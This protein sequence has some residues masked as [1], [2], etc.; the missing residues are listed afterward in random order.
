MYRMVH[1]AAE[2]SGQRKELTLR[3]FPSQCKIPC[4]IFDIFSSP[5]SEDRFYKRQIHNKSLQFYPQTRLIYKE[6]IESFV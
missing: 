2:G 1:G 4:S 3:Y 5:S 6:K